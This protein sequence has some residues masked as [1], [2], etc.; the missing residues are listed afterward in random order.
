MHSTSALLGLPFHTAQQRFCEFRIRLLLA[1]KSSITTDTTEDRSVLQWTEH[2]TRRWQKDNLFLYVPLT[3]VSH[4]LLPACT[5][6]HLITTGTCHNAGMEHPDY[7]LHP[8]PHTL[9]G[10]LP[11]RRILK[12]T[13]YMDK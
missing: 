8:L 12:A 3:P 9:R 7:Y 4:S 5:C 1:L 13:L 6:L 10:V 11:S 2:R